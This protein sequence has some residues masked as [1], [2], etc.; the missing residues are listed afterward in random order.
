MHCWL[1]SV[2]LAMAATEESTK[3]QIQLLAEARQAGKDALDFILE[4]IP[5]EQEQKAHLTSVFP[6]AKP[7]F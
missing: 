2:K 4:Y 3:D 1:D 7:R 5:E 6:R